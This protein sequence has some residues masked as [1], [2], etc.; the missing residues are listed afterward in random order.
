MPL[1]S[2]SKIHKWQMTPEQA[3]GMVTYLRSIEPES[4]GPT[5]FGGRG[6]GR[7]DGGSSSSG[8]K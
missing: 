2:W 3:N 6:G 5:D 7:R 8:G 1:E 4:Q